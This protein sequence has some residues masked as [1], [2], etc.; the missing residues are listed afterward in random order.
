[1]NRRLVLT[2]LVVGV[3]G[4]FG[5]L[6]RYV[7]NIQTVDLLFPFGTLLENLFGSLILGFITGY[8]VHK[9]LNEL[10]RTGLGVGFC[11]GFTTMSTLSADFF[12]LFATTQGFAIIYLGASIFG[13]VTLAFVGYI[14]GEKLSYRYQLPKKAGE[15][16]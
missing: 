14:L 6:F 12:G 11:G 4:A 15:R 16:K 10:W 3:G 2:F 1:M 8:L 7:I 5:T 9:K 13:G